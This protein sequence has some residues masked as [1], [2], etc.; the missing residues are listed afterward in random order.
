MLAN[1]FFFLEYRK[2]CNYTDSGQDKERVEAN[3]EYSF[4]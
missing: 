2:P 3:V 4:A 1:Q